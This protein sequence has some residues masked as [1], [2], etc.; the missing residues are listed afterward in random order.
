LEGGIVGAHV[1]RASVGDLVGNN[2]GVVLGEAVSIA[3]VGNGLLEREDEES[4]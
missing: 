4:R 3:G 2:V 1:C